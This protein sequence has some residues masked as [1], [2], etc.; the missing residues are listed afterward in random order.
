MRMFIA[1]IPPFLWDNSR[2]PVSPVNILLALY[3]H[4]M[5]LDPL[6]QVSPAMQGHNR[7]RGCFHVINIVNPPAVCLTPL[8]KF[9]KER[10]GLHGVSI[11]FSEYLHLL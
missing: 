9:A 11:S 8:S 2:F 7:V 3:L 10:H 1:H 6:I 4:W 5:S